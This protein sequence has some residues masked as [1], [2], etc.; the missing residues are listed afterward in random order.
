MDWLSNLLSSAKDI[1][2]SSAEKAAGVLKQTPAAPFVEPL[3]GVT[4]EKSGITSGGGRRRKARK[5]R[6]TRRR[7]R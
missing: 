3:P 7:R 4:P 2:S 5:S 1:I 6:K